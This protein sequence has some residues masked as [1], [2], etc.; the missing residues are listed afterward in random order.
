MRALAC[1]RPACPASSAARTLVRS[2]GVVL[3]RVH[4]S[5]SSHSIQP[6]VRSASP[7]GLS[8]RRRRSRAI[9]S[10]TAGGNA[11]AAPVPSISR[12]AAG[13]I[14]S[15]SAS[16]GDPRFM[17]CW[18]TI[19][20]FALSSATPAS[21]VLRITSRIASDSKRT[22]PSDAAVHHASA[23]GNGGPA[24]NASSSAI[25]DTS[26]SATTTGPSEPASGA[27]IEGDAAGS[28]ARHPAGTGTVTSNGRFSRYC[29]AMA[30]FSCSV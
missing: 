19:A 7:S 8:P 12:T 24:D 11:S 9:A 25:D 17:T 2:V 22:V 26:R 13:V 27:T 28:G 3:L 14:T 29:S 23:A 30:S 6:L 10:R 16:P 4:G 21:F 5:C 1:S 15:D 18:Q 20:S